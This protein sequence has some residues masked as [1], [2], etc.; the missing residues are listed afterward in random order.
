MAELVLLA[1]AATPDAWPRI[2]R[3]VE[4]ERRVALLLTR[5]DRPPAPY[6]RLGWERLAAL[7][8]AA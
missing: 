5:L 6:T 7:R 2:L 1:Q 8:E 4:A 3:S